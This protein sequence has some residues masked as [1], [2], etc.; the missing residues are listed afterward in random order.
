MRTL[1]FL[2]AS[3]DTSTGNKGLDQTK[4]ADKGQPRYGTDKQNNQ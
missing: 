2:F 4:H 1:S 3:T